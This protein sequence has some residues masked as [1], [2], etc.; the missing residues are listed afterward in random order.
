MNAGLDVE[1][2]WRHH[3]PHDFRVGSRR[4]GPGH[5]PPL[6]E[7]VAIGRLKCVGSK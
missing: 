3:L 2:H 5:V 4:I 6:L 1:H 7:K